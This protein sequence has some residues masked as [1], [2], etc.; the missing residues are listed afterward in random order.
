MREY[1]PVNLR[2]VS[3]DGHNTEESSAAVILQRERGEGGEASRLTS[4]QSPSIIIMVKVLL[5]ICR[6]FAVVRAALALYNCVWTEKKAEGQN[7]NAKD[8]YHDQMD[9]LQ[10]Q[11]FESSSFVRKIREL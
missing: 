9:K 4:F 6:N 3:F 8:Q 11:I 5:I 10:Y 1:N 7:A 2:R